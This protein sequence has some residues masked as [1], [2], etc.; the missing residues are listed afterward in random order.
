MREKLVIGNWKMNGSAL[1]IDSFVDALR[2]KIPAD[3]RAQTLIAPPACYLG[4]ASP[5]FE[6]V[7]IGLCAQDVSAYPVGAYTGEISAGMLLDLGCRFAIVGHSERRSYHGETDAVVAAKVK[8]ALRDGIRPVVCVGE[9]LAQREEGRYEQVIRQQVQAVLQV[10]EP[11]V[12]SDLVFA[13]EPVW[14]IGTGQTATPEQAQEAHRFIRSLLGAPGASVSI[15]Y[16]GSVKPENAAAIFSQPD[17]DGGL[18]G[19]ASLCAADFKAVFSA[20]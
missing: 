5:R 4:Y 8:Q 11:E 13:Y 3:F 1:H 2:Q 20:I 14:A 12:W 17:V 7:G 9:A 6:E 19:G 18:I 10:C 16:G 15:L